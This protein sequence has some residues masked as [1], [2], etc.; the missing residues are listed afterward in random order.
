LTPAEA[1]AIGPDFCLAAGEFVLNAS[2]DAMNTKEAGT[3]TDEPAPFIVK[4]GIPAASPPP[5]DDPPSMSGNGKKS[6]PKASPVSA[7]GTN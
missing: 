4:P 6:T 3:E 2:T 5:P 7:T 1:L